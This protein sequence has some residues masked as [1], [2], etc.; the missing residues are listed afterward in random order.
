MGGDSEEACHRQIIFLKVHFVH[1]IRINKV[2][3]AI[4]LSHIIEDA[5]FPYL[6]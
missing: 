1:T 4:S 3:P 2:S 5:N 6:L